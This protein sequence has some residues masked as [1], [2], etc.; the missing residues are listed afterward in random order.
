[1][2]EK[3]TVVE[4]EKLRDCIDKAN[5][6]IRGILD[7]TKNLE[8]IEAQQKILALN[9]S[10]EAARAGDAGRGFAI[11]ATTV[12]EL[13]A[14]SAEVNS[15]IKHSLEELDSIIVKMKTLEK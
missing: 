15:A 7:K 3:D 1:M 6:C 8:K 14:S 11:V 2:E 13:A 12:G 10:I 5:E 4:M 9:A